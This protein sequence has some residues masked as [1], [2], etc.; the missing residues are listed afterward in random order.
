MAGRPLLIL[1]V[2][3]V[4]VGALA[5]GAAGQGTSFPECPPGSPP[6]PPPAVDVSGSPATERVTAGRPFTIEYDAPIGVIVQDTLGPAGTTFLGNDAGGSSLEPTVPAAGPAGFTVRYYSAD[7]RR[8]TECVQR[9]AFTVPVEVGDLLPARIGY[10]LGDRIGRGERYVKLPRKGILANTN[11]FAGLSWT[12]SETTALVPV[13]AELRGGRDLRRAP[14]PTSPLARL[15]IPDPCQ[16]KDAAAGVPGAVL[17]FD[18]GSAVDEGDRALAV[19]HRRKTGARYWLR[20]T[21]GD[22]LLG[23][24]RYYVAFRPAARRF[25]A[26]WVLAPEA[27]FER[28]R[29]RRPRRGDPTIPLGFRKFPIPPCPR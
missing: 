28:A 12:C 2:V 29:C 24:L 26:V 5:P 19:E 25:S 6:L 1:L 16:L 23:E 14:S 3:V 13:V 27:A 22:R 9:L 10:G 20:I 11:V 21:Q 17:R 4:A 15:A 8:G 18:G 7:A